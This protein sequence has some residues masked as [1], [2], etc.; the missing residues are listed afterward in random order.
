MPRR[1]T[2]FMPLAKS[3]IAANPGLAAHEVVSMALGYSDE[4]GI[5]ISAAANPRASLTA[6][7]HKS[8]EDYGLERERGADGTFRYYLKGHGPEDPI[9]YRFPTVS[10]SA[11][12]SDYPAPSTDRRGD[13]DGQNPQTEEVPGTFTPSVSSQTHSTRGGLWSDE[14]CCIE[15]PD[16]LISK[17]RALVELG[18]YSNEQEAHSDL[19]REGLRAVLA[20]PLA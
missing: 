18:K 12:S 17:V 10:N 7:L 1:I 4:E 8:H 3:I 2:G 11:V 5:P 14:G 19:V 6:T 13:Y 20:R 16:E 9:T 15:L